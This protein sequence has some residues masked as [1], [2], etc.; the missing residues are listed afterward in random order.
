MARHPYDAANDILNRQFPARERANRIMREQFPATAAA[1]RVMAES[2]LIP[3]WGRSLPPGGRGDTQAPLQPGTAGGLQDGGRGVYTGPR[4]ARGPHYVGPG[5]F[6]G[7]T[8][9]AELI[10]GDVARAA[11]SGIPVVDIRVWAERLQAA[12]V[13]EATIFAAYNDAG[14]SP[15]LAAEQ[16]RGDTSD[17]LGDFVGALE[18]YGVAPEIILGA[19]QEAGGRLADGGD[20]NPR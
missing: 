17:F 16:A 1:D 2:G 20:R 9:V 4:T 5:R 8:P 7:R 14:G 11:G 3:K 19:Y 6:V 15:D 18:G 12:G 10:V 13:P